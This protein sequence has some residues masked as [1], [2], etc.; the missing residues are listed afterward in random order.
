[1][2]DGGTPVKNLNELGVLL[3]GLQEHW[4]LRSGVEKAKE[5]ADQTRDGAPT[6]L[7]FP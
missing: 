6:P 7:V 3:R 4:F 2:N 5:K 1:M